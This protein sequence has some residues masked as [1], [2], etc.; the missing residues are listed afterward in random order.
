MRTPGEPNEIEKTMNLKDFARTIDAQDMVLLWARCDARTAERAAPGRIAVAIGGGFPRDSK[1]MQGPLLERDRDQLSI[2]E[3]FFRTPDAALPAALRP[4]A[5]G[6]P[7]GPQHFAFCVK[8][9]SPDS[10]FAVLLVLARQAGIQDDDALRRWQDEIGA[11]NS[12]AMPE[13]PERSWPALASSLAHALFPDSPRPGD[14]PTATDL[15]GFDRSW[16]STF[17][18]LLNTLADGHD[19]A[20]MPRQ[21]RGHGRGAAAALARLRQ[22]YLDCLQHALV[23]QVS[24]PL[25]GAA[26]R[27]VTVDTLL[28]VEHEFSDALKLF[29]RV[30]REHSPGCRG[31]GLAVSY[32]PSAEDW[33]RFTVHSDPA[34]G[35]DLTGLWAKLESL[36]TA[37]WRGEDGR[38]DRPAGAIVGADDAAPASFVA[39]DLTQ[40]A[41]AEGRA[42]PLSG[43]RNCWVNPW[44]VSPDASLIGSPGK[45]IDGI[46]AGATRLAWNE[47][48]DAVW[49]TFMPMAEL[50]LTALF[51]G[52]GGEVK[53]APCQRLLTTAACHL[54]DAPSQR[55]LSFRYLRWPRDV[56]RADQS[57]DTGDLSETALRLLATVAQKPEPAGELSHADLV[58]PDTYRRVQLNGGFA[59]IAE[60]GCILIDDWRDVALNSRQMF[61]AMRLAANLCAHAEEHSLI[62]LDNCRELEETSIQRSDLMDR[63]LY[64]LLIGL[65]EHR[66]RLATTT[67]ER[68]GLQLADANADKLYAELVTHWHIRERLALADQGYARLEMTIRALM[69]SRAALG[70]KIISFWG[71][72][73]AAAGGL[74]K[75]A[76]SALNAT[77]LESGV[78]LDVSETVA[79]NLRDVADGGMFLLFVLLFYRLVRRIF[80]SAR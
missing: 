57:A 18:F 47:V 79:G 64:R 29:G 28:C 59:V 56:Q 34:L 5:D 22:V 15:T 48:A 9:A 24:V 68:S 71:L 17:Q 58:P 13:E 30:D 16:R 76:V 42:R 62:Y 2:S 37:K 38:I 60:R 65:A 46:E 63:S 8:D 26:A 61:E 23:L 50:E 4:A 40:I 49:T 66:S 69:D 44:Y 25:R 51:P 73:V 27:R 36:E 41:R 80:R 52:P 67:V 53:E 20:R 77:L 55:A 6:L 31:F 12:G 54:G 33:N 10:L 32:R 39:A 72:P 43:V 14:R 45:D 7:R 70:I 74:A 1:L 35:L 75:P 3:S 78:L 11:W 19:P 21:L